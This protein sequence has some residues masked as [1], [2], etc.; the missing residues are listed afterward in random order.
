MSNTFPEQDITQK[1]QK[2]PPRSLA[3]WVTFTIATSIVGA[4]AALVIY[5]WV[6]QKDSPP[7]LTITPQ[8]ETRQV[9]GQFYIP[10][11]L[12]NTG[13]ETAESVRVIAELQVNGKVE[14]SSDQEIDFLSSGETAAGAFVFSRNPQQ[15]K[16]TMRVVSYK[17]P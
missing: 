12:T 13:G 7:V 3:E 2:R 8:T 11:K 16:L 15:G 17:L 6:T 4:I 1:E 14:E 10:F 5:L 9:E